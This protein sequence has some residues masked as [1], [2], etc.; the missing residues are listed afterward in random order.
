MLEKLTPVRLSN[1]WATFRCSPEL[2]VK[3]KKLYRYK[4]VG[5]EFSEAYRAGA[6][7]GYVNYFQRSRVPAGLFLDKL[8]DLRQRYLVRVEDERE[9]PQFR[10]LETDG[11]RPYQRE[12]V[13]AMIAASA[14]GGLV[15]S[16][17]GSGK[18]HLAGAFLRSLR[19]AGCFVV[20]ELTLLEQARR[21]I[22]QVTGEEVGVVGKSEFQPKR[23]TVA[24]V[25]TLHRHRDKPK[26]LEWLRGL[27][28]MILDEIHV[29]LNRRSIDVIW[30]ARPRAVFGL[31]ATL[32]MQKPHVRVPATALA[33]PVV[34][35]Y[36]ICQGVAE[37]YLSDGVIGLVEFQDP[38]RGIAPGYF[39]LNAD[40]RHF[41][42]PGSPS[43]KYRYHIALNRAR[44]DIVEALAREAVRRDCHTAVLVEQRRHLSALAR[45][46][47]DVP[48]AVMCGDRAQQE[49]LEAQRAMDAGQLP[50]ILANR[51]FAKGIDLR[52]LDAVI[53]ATAMAGHNGALQR[54]GRGARKAEGKR[55]LIYLDIADAGS[56]Y[57]IAARSRQRALREVGCPMIKMRWEGDAA[58]MFAAL[59]GK[60]EWNGKAMQG[61]A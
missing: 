14:T 22:A 58:K 43:A 2:Q 56:W 55:G 50:L 13:E 10:K 33:G 44:N 40:G 57:A 49:R 26:F 51:V 60:V 59:E 8:K 20:D 18:T 54:Y 1:R 12:A 38:L 34:F 30:K 48:H 24:T 36:P 11:M 35:R 15:L 37:G 42:R 7:D 9:R 41:V 53:D 29:A 47:R 52:T 16:A 6:W 61:D 28:V 39:V 5:A 46:L 4:A 21:E 31:T 27:D 23:I 17:T 25:Q 19:G 3:L 45:R 32:E